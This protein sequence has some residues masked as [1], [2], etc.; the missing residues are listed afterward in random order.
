MLF[1]SG[2]ESKTADHHGYFSYTSAENSVWEDL[3]ERQQQVLFGRAAPEFLRGLEALQ[4]PLDRVPQVDDVNA[5]LNE[6]T[7]FGVEPVEAMIS[8]EAFFYLLA[9]R[10]FPVATFVRKREEIDYLP[11]PDIFHEIYG[12][13]PL[14]TIPEYADAVENFG[15]V[16]LDLGPAYFEPIHRIFWFTIEFGLTHTPDGL[17]LYGAGIASST[18]ESLS[19][20]E[21]DPTKQR[22]FDLEEIINRDYLISELQ[23]T[24]Y[25]LPSLSELYDLA[26]NLKTK[27]WTHS[28][29]DNRYLADRSSS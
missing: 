29:P 16:A 13:C 3:I 24:Y 2:Y 25:I 26:S 11:E 14:L 8:D 4:L 1:S 6:L 27:L 10:K 28:Y 17:R 18:K 15:R 12:H 23:T 21:L 22:L 9:N 20:L 7:G 19:C 5:R